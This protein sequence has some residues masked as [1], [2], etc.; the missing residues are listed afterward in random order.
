MLTELLDQY[1]VNF[2]VLFR[3]PNWC[4]NMLKTEARSTCVAALN[5]PFAHTSL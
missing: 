2:Q 3:W 4:T 1:T 5:L